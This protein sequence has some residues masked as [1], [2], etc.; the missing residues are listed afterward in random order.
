MMTPIVFAAALALG[1]PATVDESLLAGLPTREV[2]LTAHGVTQKCSGPDITTVL[3]KLGLPQG[4][5]LRGPALASGVIVRARDGYAVLFSL[6]EFDAMLGNEGAVVATQCDGHAIADKDGPYRLI[7]PGDKRP[8]RAV[9]QMATI[10]LIGDATAPTA[11]H[12]AH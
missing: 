9:R 10:E 6:A 7:V 5:A 4:E 1:T 12:D 2:T 11:H 8:A 3:A